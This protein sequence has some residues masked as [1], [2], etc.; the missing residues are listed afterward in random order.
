[1]CCIINVKKLDGVRRN[2]MYLQIMV[3]LPQVSKHTYQLVVALPYI[4]G[5]V[6]ATSNNSVLISVVENYILLDRANVSLTI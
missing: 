6:T 1:M 2:E 5:P 3:R 4:N